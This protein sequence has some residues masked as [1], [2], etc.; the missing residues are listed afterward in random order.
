MVEV[1]EW[2]R[3]DTARLFRVPTADDDKYARGVVALRTGSP[4]YPG[5]AV[6][7]VEAAWRTGAG[8]V[9]YVGAERV[10]DAVLAR[11]PETVAGADVGRSRIDAW[12]IG[13]GTDPTDRDDAEQAA[14]EAIVAGDAAVVIDAG[15]LDLAGKARAPFLVTPHAREF[16]RL[17][18]QL[19]ISTSEEDRA[20]AARRTADRVGGT[21]LLKGART[22]IASPDGGV[23]AVDAGTGWL[24]TAGTGDVLAG[25]LGAV[26]AANQ[27]RPIAE[28]AAAGAWIHGQ[29][30]RV[31]AGMSDGGTGHP[32]V[33]MDVAAAL[34]QAIADVLA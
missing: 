6:L 20:S 34:P 11:R 27:G 13:S 1:R 10:A 23:I 7:G 14:L 4:A 28:V 2:T 32:I 19:G 26:L 3:D 12:V 9:R 15:A 5:A 31:A 29:A 17:Q 24:A 8:F 30:G 25:V 22:L 21:V 16:A 18:E 33:A